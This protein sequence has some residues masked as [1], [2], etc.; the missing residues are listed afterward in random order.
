MSSKKI[1]VLVSGILLIAPASAGAQSS[2]ENQVVVEAPRQVTGNSDPTRLFNIPS[3]AVHPDDPSTVALAVGDTRQGGCGLWVT[4]D[5]GL[6]WANTAETLLPEDQPFCIQRPRGYTSYPQFAPDGTLYVSMSGSSLE[7]GHPNG[8]ISLLVARTDDLGRTHQTVTVAEPDRITLDPEDYGNE[9]EPVEGNLWHKFSA[10]AINPENPDQVFVGWRWGLWGLD[11]QRPES[12]LPFRPYAALSE[13][14]GQTWGEPIDLLSV[15]EGVE[16]YGG[17]AAL[18]LVGPDGTLYAFAEESTRPAPEGEPSP[19]A[20]VLQFKSTDGGKTWATSV[21]G[22]GGQNVDIANPAVDLD[23]GNLYLA[24]AAQDVTTKDEPES[25]SEVYVTSSTDGG[26]TWNEPINIT[27]DDSTGG[28]DQYLPGISVAP[29]GR[30]D[31]AWYDF[32]NDPFVTPEAP[33]VPE[34]EVEQR[35]WDV[36]YSYS[37]DGGADWSPNMRVTETFVDGSEGAT[38]ANSD[39]RGP[40]GIAS[41]DDA[42][43]LAWSDSRATGRQGDAEDAYFSRVRFAPPAELAGN[44]A[45][46]A[47]WLWGVSGAGIA[48]ALAGLALVV[49]TRWS[50]A[51]RGGVA[52]PARAGA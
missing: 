51:G 50:R 13:D 36:Y 29:N 46:G 9:G 32:R 6:S 47:R 39:T 34:S 3:L 4:R 8:P 17:S 35:Y 20:R 10:L 19:N 14:G 25:P 22:D 21:V 44:E 42:A 49:G 7:T 1:V 45:G 26:E 38:F 41:A 15:S 5:G 48:L 31:V 43:Y 23:N 18:P 11:L 27:D 24:W 37:T 33:G 2:D 28:A 30:V 16:A 52:Q 12:S 40:M